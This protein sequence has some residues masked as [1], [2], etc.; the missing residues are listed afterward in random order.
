MLIEAKTLLPGTRAVAP[1]LVFCPPVP[2][3]LHTSLHPFGSSS[4]SRIRRGPVFVGL[5]DSPRP[6]VS[7]RLVRS[8]GRPR[9]RGVAISFWSCLD[10]NTTRPKTRRVCHKATL[11]TSLTSLAQACSHWTGNSSRR[12]RPWHTQLRTV[13]LHPRNPRCTLSRQRRCSYS[14]LPSTSSHR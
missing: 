9:L 5:Q 4:G 14:I 3:P 12:W 8:C 7:R 10:A 2:A 1:V 6:G 11:V 13:P